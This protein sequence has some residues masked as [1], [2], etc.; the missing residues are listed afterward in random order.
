[1]RLD[2]HDSQLVESLRTFMCEAEC[3]GKSRPLTY[4]LLN[5]LK[6]LEPLAS[7][8]IL[9]LKSRIQMPLPGNYENN[10]VYLS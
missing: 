5:S 3:I 8:M 4:D 1:M 10:D 7:N 9:A 2:Q 6:Y